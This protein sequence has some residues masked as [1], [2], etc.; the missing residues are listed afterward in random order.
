MLLDATAASTLELLETAH[1]RSAR[2]SLVGTLDRTRTPMGARLL[3]Q[4]LLRPS[5]DLGEIARRHEAVA[6]LLDAPGVRAALRRRLAAIGDLER[7]TSRAALGVAHARD[8][9]GLRASLTQI[10][11]LREEMGALEAPLCRAV[12]EDIVAPAGLQKLLDEALED[13][14]PLVLREG[15]LIREGWNSELRELKQ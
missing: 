14:P 7:L 8:L 4:W 9:V 13:E 11:A 3:R 10:P 6:A 15:R 12:A 1:E 5:L 2:G